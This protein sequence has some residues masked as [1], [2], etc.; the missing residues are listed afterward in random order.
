MEKT[1]VANLIETETRARLAAEGL[2]IGLPVVTKAEIRASA[3]KIWTAIAAP[4]SLVQFHPFVRSNPV[5][6]W[7]GADAADSVVYHSGLIYF[8]R[9]HR[10][11]PGEGYCLELGVGARPSARVSWR[12]I[13]Q[14][15]SAKLAIFVFPLL[16][17]TL[18]NDRK[19]AFLEKHFGDNLQ[20]YLDSVVSG[21]KHWVE[22]GTQVEPDQF[23]R[24]PIYS[25]A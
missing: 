22:T 1:S 8:R 21:A 7:H 17:T 11:L 24:N 19:D 14:Q 4:G 16:D 5:E 6:R 20:H 2:E 25:A 3:N 18:P 23:G 10:W 12:I 9:F 13:Q 15:S